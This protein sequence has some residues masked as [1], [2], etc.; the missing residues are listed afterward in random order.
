MNVFE[1]TNGLVGMSAVSDLVNGWPGGI[2]QASREG[3]FVSPIYL[4]NQLYADAL[5]REILTSVVD[6][7]TFDSS[8]EGKQVPKLDVVVSRSKDGK[9]IFIKAVNCDLEHPLTTTVSIH[10]QKSRVHSCLLVVVVSAR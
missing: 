2:I 5:G 10:A 7:P 9:R 3:S 8:R 4:V 1:R 6:S